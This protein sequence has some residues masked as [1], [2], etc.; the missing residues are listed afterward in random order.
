MS[1]ADDLR[2]AA[3]RLRDTAKA[4]E[5][6][7]IDLR[8]VGWHAED[9]VQRSCP[10]IVAQGGDEPADHAQPVRYIADAET[11]ELAAWIALA[12]PVL[13]E[14]HAALFVE[15]AENVEVEGHNWQPNSTDEAV[16]AVA[17][18]ILG[19]KEEATW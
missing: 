14:P 1:A 8:G 16:I 7:V 17:R 13:A 18:V 11:P 10:C 19:D 5:H 3:A 15:V 2:A 12:S 4:C 6:D 9:C